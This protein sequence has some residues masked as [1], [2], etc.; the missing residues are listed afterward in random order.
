MYKCF[1]FLSFFSLVSAYG[2]L[3]G[4]PYP[5]LEDIKLHL[6]TDEKEEFEAV[7][8]KVF[9][10]VCQQ[11]EAPDFKNLELIGKAN[12]ALMLPNGLALKY[13][14]PQDYRDWQW[15][16]DTIYG[17]FSC[18]VND[19]SV[20]NEETLRKAVKA[21]ETDRLGRTM[22]TRA[23]TRRITEI[24]K[25]CQVL[26]RE[27]FAKKLLTEPL[28]QALYDNEDAAYSCF[29]VK[30]FPDTIEK[31]AFRFDVMYSQTVKEAE[32]EAKKASVFALRFS[33]GYDFEN[34]DFGG[35]RVDDNG[36]CWGSNQPQLEYLEVNG[37]SIRSNSLNFDTRLMERVWWHP[38]WASDL[39]KGEKKILREA[40][41]E[42][43][44]EEEKEEKRENSEK[45]KDGLKSE[46]ED[47][48]VFT[49]ED[50]KDEASEVPSNKRPRSPDSEDEASEENLK[51]KKE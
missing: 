19:A 13:Y 49:G 41:E 15:K 51:R 17:F 31:N 20:F 9:K 23:D 8:K 30:F 18:T 45:S 21:S 35:N 22:L 43:R 2:V 27:E 5:S 3:F 47:L 4:T 48:R 37:D 1:R 29:D 46:E 36:K 10:D 25:V 39:C 26:L 34:H 50:K 16:F 24:V 44:E 6:N 32:R 12:G 14:K 40:E 7:V 38:Y 33:F 28:L 42:E 11:A